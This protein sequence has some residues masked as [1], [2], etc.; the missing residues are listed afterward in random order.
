MSGSGTSRNSNSKDRRTVTFR[1]GEGE[2]N[3]Y[4]DILRE[5]GT[6]L[7]SL[8]RL[9]IKLVIK[10]YHHYK[11]GG[12]FILRDKDGQE[13][14]LIILELQGARLISGQTIEQGGGGLN[15]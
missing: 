13:H 9:A 1:L 7:S 3:S 2:E 6:S 8:M 12:Q 15:G 4:D 14:D 10:L 11:Q 5:L